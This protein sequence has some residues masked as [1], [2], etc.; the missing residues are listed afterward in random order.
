[1]MGLDD[2]GTCNVAKIPGASRAIFNETSP[3]GLTLEQLLGPV[4]DASL[5]RK[6]RDG[7]GQ[8][9]ES[10][11]LIDGTKIFSGP[12]EFS[13]FPVCWSY[14]GWAQNEPKGDIQKGCWNLGVLGC[15]IVRNAPF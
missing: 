14:L 10:Q 15:P 4:L 8:P 13:N 12:N 5:G 1:M 2:D 6:P 11:D 9:K 3:Y 7:D